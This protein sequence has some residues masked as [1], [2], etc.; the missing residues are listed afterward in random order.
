MYLFRG[1]FLLNFFL[2]EMNIRAPLYGEAV[3]LLNPVLESV[4]MVTTV[5]FLVPSSLLHIIQALQEQTVMT[6]VINVSQT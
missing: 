3:Y 2:E 1:F 4:T 5:L 6:V